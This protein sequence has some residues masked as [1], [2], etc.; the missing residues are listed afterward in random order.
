[1]RVGLY[2]RGGELGTPFSN[3]MGAPLKLSHFIFA[4][5]C[6]KADEPH[7]EPHLKSS[8]AIHT[9]FKI[10]QKLCANL[11]KEPF[12]NFHVCTMSNKMT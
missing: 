10:K 9:F 11:L 2:I 8:E 6:L 12:N 7:L 1:L 5:F 4:L 3:A